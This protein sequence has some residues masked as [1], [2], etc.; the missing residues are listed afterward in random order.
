MLISRISKMYADQEAV[1]HDSLL[2][3]KLA[4]AVYLPV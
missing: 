2:L 4:I 3:Q 1:I